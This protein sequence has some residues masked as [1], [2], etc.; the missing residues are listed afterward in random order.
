MFIIVDLGALI[1]FLAI[2][3][4]GLGYTIISNIGPILF[5]IT[6]I[7]A[8]F[9]GGYIFFSGFTKKTISHKIATCVK[10]LMIMTIFMYVLLMIDSAAWGDNLSKG[11][12]IVIEHFDF[13]MKN[14]FFTSLIV[15]LVLIEVA[16]IPGQIKVLADI[17]SKKG[18]AILNII[19]I[20]LVIAIY[21]A[22]FQITVKDNF[23]NNIG[24][25]AELNNPKY[26]VMQNVDIRND[27]LLF[28]KTGSFKVGTKLYSH[29]SSMEYK[30]TEYV[31]VT[32]GKQ[33]GYVRAEALKT[34]Y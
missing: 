23:N 20:F 22:T 18:E 33:L 7:I 30:D 6:A 13:L 26:E 10:G 21:V 25:F 29:G 12:Y 3:G 34:L 15:G 17:T 4:I 31:E 19:S 5:M 27:D 11:S 28:V 24:F 32:D 8:F 9:G 2:L 14:I 1:I 16:L